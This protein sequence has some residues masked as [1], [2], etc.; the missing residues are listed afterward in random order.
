LS[1]MHNLGFHVLRAQKSQSEAE[2]E[3]TLADNTPIA[4]IQQIT[5]TLIPSRG[6]SF[7]GISYFH[8]DHNVQ[9]GETYYYAIKDLDEDGK[10]TV[11]LDH[12]VSVTIPPLEQ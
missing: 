7:W 5:K 9:P 2:T 6:I 3:Y 1:E 10:E 11:H 8:A 12:I 4:Q